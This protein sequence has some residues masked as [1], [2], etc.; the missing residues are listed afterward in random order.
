MAL[1]HLHDLG[2]LEGIGHAG[3]R[4]ELAHL[5]TSEE[6]TPRLSGP[7]CLPLR[8]LPCA[9]TRASTPALRYVRRPWSSLAPA[10]RYGTL[11]LAAQDER[12]L[13]L[14]LRL[15]RT[16]DSARALE[17]ALFDHRQWPDADDHPLAREH[18]CAS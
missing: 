1:R 5:N 3:Q 2:R 12:A 13:H 9:R 17:A 4:R 6:P 11:L 15:P 8:L 16:V 7:H 18:P 14:R 10:L